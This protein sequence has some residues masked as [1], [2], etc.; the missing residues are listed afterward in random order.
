MTNAIK[1]VSNEKGAIKIF[2]DDLPLNPREEFDNF[3]HMICWHRGYNLGDEHCYSEPREFLEHLVYDLED[4]DDDIMEEMEDEQLL[5]I[6]SKHAV[7]LPL[8][9]YDHSGITM[10]TTGFS[11]QWDSGQVGWTY[12]THSEIEKE[13]GR[14]D[15]ERAEN[16]LK[17]E[18]EIYDQYLTGD[19]YYFT[20]EDA[21]GNI[22]DSCGGFYGLDYIVEEISSYINEEYQDLIDELKT[23]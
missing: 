21:D 5:E 16:L 20:L 8:Y 23:A 15:L 22:V 3:G 11:C 1:E 10:N 4:V 19:I 2:Q 12:A 14:L 13:Y 9:I 6:I 7:I 18:V 17:G